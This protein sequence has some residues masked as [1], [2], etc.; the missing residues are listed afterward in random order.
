MFGELLIKNVIII[1]L[2]LHIPQPFGNATG[3]IFFHEKLFVFN[4]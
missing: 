3:K 4:Q 1:S 2:Q